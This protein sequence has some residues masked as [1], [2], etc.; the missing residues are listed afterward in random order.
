[1]KKYKN[2][3]LNHFDIMEGGNIDIVM[4]SKPNKKFG[5]KESNRPQSEIKDYPIT[6]VPNFEY[7]GTQTFTDKK[8]I[9]INSINGN[10]LMPKL[11]Y[12]DKSLVHF[13]DNNYTRRDIKIDETVNITAISTSE[14]NIESKPISVKFNK[15]PAGRKV[16]LFTEYD[17]QYTAG[18]AEGL[19][20]QISGGKEW[21]LGAWQGYSGVNFIA[22]VDL[23][24]MQ[25]VSRIGGNFIQET[26]SWIFL[27]TKVNY[28][29]SEDGENFTLLETIPSPIHE[30]DEIPQS[31]TFFTKT[32]FSAR[33][34]KVEAIN[35]GKNPDWHISAGEKSWLFID[36][37]IIE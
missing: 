20:D 25:E 13:G 27:P 17:S 30:R 1:G 4:D 33:Y 21:R 12:N 26:K 15:I 2:T 23:G 6:I 34:I 32:P 19:I 28:Y 7:E 29:I 9:Y 37:I 18:G 8:Q 5:K 10:I 22:V 31:Y 36:E 14:D 24:K 3:F 11:D 16:K 35:I